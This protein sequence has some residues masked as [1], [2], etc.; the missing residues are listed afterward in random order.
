[1]KHFQLFRK[2]KL[3]SLRQV[4]TSV[5]VIL[6]LSLAAKTQVNPHCQHTDSFLLLLH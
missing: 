3:T 2:A 1:M 4:P 6:V 5:A